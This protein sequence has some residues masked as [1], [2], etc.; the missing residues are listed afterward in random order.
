IAILARGRAGLAGA[1][2]QASRLGA[3]R[4]LPLPVDVADTDAVE[5]AAQRVEDELGAIDVW[6]NCAMTSVF[7]T[8]LDV[9]PEE[10]RRVMEV[11]F[12]GY[13]NGTQSALR[14]MLPRDRGVVVQVGSAL[15]YRG[16][17]AQS[18]YCAAKHAI[19]GFDDSL[20][21]ELYSMG[22]AVTVSAV[23]MP[24]LNTPQF[25]WV[26]TRLPK[27]PQPVPP[28]YQPEV[29]ARA[30]LWAADHR[31]REIDVGASTIA[32]RLANKVAPGLLDRYLGRSGI[33]SQ[34]T[35]EP[36]DLDRWR[37]NL[38]EPADD[39]VDHGAHGIFDDRAHAS[40]AAL[41]GVTHK[42]A[43]AAAAVGLGVVAAA[44]AR[45]S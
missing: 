24:A 42:P 7:A 36:I 31:P 16:I 14:R 17:P 43:L 4:V 30:V 19:Q 25:G 20:R 5:A 40:S 32:T 37:D 27:H 44:V 23:Q 18:A 15:A 6:V 12:L 2:T 28:I 8:V 35:D 29:A 34:Q 21:A 45:R 38:Y 9:R 13:V 10:Y 3:D 26:R 39:D 1:E 41:W 33:E 11:I 22:S